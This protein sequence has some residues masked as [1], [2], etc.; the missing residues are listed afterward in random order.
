MKL[1]FSIEATSFEQLEEHIFSKVIESCK[2]NVIQQALILS[3]RTSKIREVICELTSVDCTYLSTFSKPHANIPFV[4]AQ[5]NTSE[6]SGRIQPQQSTWLNLS[7][8]VD[9]TF[10]TLHTF[11]HEDQAESPD[12]GRSDSGLRHLRNLWT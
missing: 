8:S 4:P 11:G 6:R 3:H 2:I 12:R 9:C 5:K 10:R 1:A 7:L